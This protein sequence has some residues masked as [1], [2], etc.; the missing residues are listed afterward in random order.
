MKQIYDLFQIYF[1]LYFVVHIL[2][3]EVTER[4]LVFE[5]Q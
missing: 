5:Y 4:N 3:Q 2:K 1:I